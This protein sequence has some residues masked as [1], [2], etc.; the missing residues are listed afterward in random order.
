MPVLLHRN[1]IGTPTHALFDNG[2]IKWT[3]HYS[4]DFLTLGFEENAFALEPLLE[5]YGLEI[6]QVVT[7]E[8][9]KSFLV[10]GAKEVPWRW[11]MPKKLFTKRFKEFLS[12]IAEVEKLFAASEYPGFFANSNYVLNSLKP[13]KFDPVLVRSFIGKGGAHIL[14]SFLKM[15][16]DNILPVPR[17]DRVSTKT[18]RL[19]I[20]GGPQILTLKKELRSVFVSQFSDGKLYEIDFVSLEPRVALNIANVHASNDVYLS[21]IQHN[22]LQIARDTAKLAVLC[23]LY[24]AGK[25]KLEHVMRSEKSS[26]TAISLIRAVEKYFKLPAL[27]SRLRAQAREDQLI[28]NHFG[29]PITVDAMRD[30]ILVNNFLQSSAADVALAGFSDFI[31]KFRNK[32]NP[33][34]IIHDAL[35]IDVKHKNLSYIKEYVEKGFVLPSLGN[36]PLKL[37]EF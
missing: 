31:K 21:F 8:V 17:Y 5:L 35:I 1:L 23:S 22:N 2:R 33:L 4:D 34:F 16:K 28:K 32:C 26:I 14:E 24:G 36:F 9:K 12:Q 30:N 6:Q 27:K 20:K 13:S 10:C 29:R 15:Q 7:E 11:V 3:T 18:G 25:N 37:S 19:T